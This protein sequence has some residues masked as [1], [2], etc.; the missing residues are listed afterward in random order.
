MYV[1]EGEADLADLLGD[2][3]VAVLTWDERRYASP[4]LAHCCMRVRGVAGDRVP[5][6]L[7]QRGTW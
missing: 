1:L 7:A 5:V 2:V 3:E 6:H 4:Y